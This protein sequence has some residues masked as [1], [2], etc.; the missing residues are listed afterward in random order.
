[1]RGPLW[2][3]GGWRRWRSRMGLSPDASYASDAAVALRLRSGCR[4]APLAGTR[5]GDA[6]AQVVQLPGQQL[7][8]VHLRDAE[9]LADLGLGHVPVE[10]HYQQA[11]LAFGQV[12]PVRPNGLHV[13]RVL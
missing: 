8:H 10:P 2:F 11:L 12:A 4:G 5:A 13:E 6:L 7:G 1:M 9:P 3:S